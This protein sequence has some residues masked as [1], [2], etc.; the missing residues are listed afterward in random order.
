LEMTR[1]HVLLGLFEP[2]TNS[3]E[4]PVSSAEITELLDFCTRNVTE[5]GEQS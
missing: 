3:P 4:N 1:N 5:T 2:R